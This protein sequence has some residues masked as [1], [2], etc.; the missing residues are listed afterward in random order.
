[1]IINTLA[2]HEWYSALIVLFTQ[3]LMIYFRTVNIIYTTRNHML[4]AILSNVGITV[5][6][7]M[8][9]I[10]GVNSIISGQWPSILSFIIGGAIGTYYG[11]R[12]KY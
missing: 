4:G 2:N 9:T 7:L 8:S 11:M 10:V 3:M 5:M 6:W 12:Y 1:M